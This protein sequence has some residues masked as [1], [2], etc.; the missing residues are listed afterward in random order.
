MGSIRKVLKDNGIDIGKIM[1]GKS[2]VF[3]G[4]S[5]TSSEKIGVY[6]HS[7]NDAN[8]RHITE[9]NKFTPEQIEI[10]KSSMTEEEQKIATI[11]I[12]GN[13]WAYL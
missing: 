3:P 9:G 2:E 7:L 1:S 6:L 5:L 10:V 12:G 8:L 4:T 11:I 13:L